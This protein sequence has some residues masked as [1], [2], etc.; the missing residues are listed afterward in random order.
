MNT[1]NKLGPLLGRLF[2]LSD[3]ARPVFSGVPAAERERLMRSKTEY[4]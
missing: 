1:L 4:L 3:T 2:D